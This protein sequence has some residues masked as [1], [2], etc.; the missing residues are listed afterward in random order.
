MGNILT[1]APFLYFN[2]S[3][4][5]LIT[6][7]LAIF[8]ILT[9]FPSIL[10]MCSRVDHEEPDADRIVVDIADQNTGEI[11]NSMVVQLAQRRT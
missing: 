5:I 2:A 9:I 10:R 11:V 1:Q 3:V 4:S 7:F 6:T 8:L